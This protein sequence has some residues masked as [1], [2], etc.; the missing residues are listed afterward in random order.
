MEVR[1]HAMTLNESGAVYEIEDCFGRQRYVFVPV[2][3]GAIGGRPRSS[4]SL[5]NDHLVGY[6]DPAQNFFTKPRAYLR[7]EKGEIIPV[8]YHD[9][10]VLA[11]FFEKNAPET[12]V[13][14]YE[15][16]A[17]RIKRLGPCIG[18]KPHP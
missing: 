14:P 5:T 3:E 15:S 8:S 4:V 1:L 18:A 2:M 12:L 10:K 13:P 16:R 9:R 17:E 11:A 7:D 6:L